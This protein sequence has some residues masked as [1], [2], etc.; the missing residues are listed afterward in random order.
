MN[1]GEQKKAQLFVAREVLDHVSLFA[2]IVYFLA[3][4]LLPSFLLY[5]PVETI[6]RMF[7]V[8]FL[9]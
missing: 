3:F 7:C 2:T 6:L 1:G 4:S 9:H 8:N 5:L